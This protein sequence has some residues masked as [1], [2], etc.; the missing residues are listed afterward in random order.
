MKTKHIET[1]IDLIG[2]SHLYQ[3]NIGSILAEAE[4]AG[5]THLLVSP[6]D[7]VNIKS[8]AM[9]TGVGSWNWDKRT[10]WGME[11]IVKER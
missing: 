3:A 5:V 9:Q 4:K 8:W 7:W 11:I 10:I 1:F 2:D 6:S